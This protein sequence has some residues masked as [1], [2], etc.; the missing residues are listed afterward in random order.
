[1]AGGNKARGTLA[2]PDVCRIVIYVLFIKYIDMENESIALPSYDE[3][4]SVGYLALIYGKKVSPKELVEYMEAIEKD[5]MYTEG[6][7]SDEMDKLL[8]RA[9]TNYVQK[10]FS[11]IDEAGFNEKNSYMWQHLLC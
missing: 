8:K 10:V 1:M 9:E 4:F 5:I 7:V 6:I 2:M 3:K 11:I